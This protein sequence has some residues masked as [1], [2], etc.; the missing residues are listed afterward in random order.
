MALDMSIGSARRDGRLLRSEESRR[1]IAD[2]LIELIRAGELLPTAQQVADR[3]KVGL[4]TVYRHFDDGESLFATISEQ[5]RA[6][7]QPLIRTPPPD[8]PLAERIAGAVEH[9]ARLFEKIAPFQRSER[10]RR[11]SSPF[12]RSAHARFVREQRAYLLEWLPEISALPPALQPALE[13]ALSFDAWDALRSDLGL[14][15]QRAMRS[16]RALLERA[17]GVS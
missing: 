10:I 7:V 6:S 17:L 4:R 12:L 1:R 5:V 3:A 8:A 9:R 13:Q 14:S 15:E 2:A 16:L 11:P